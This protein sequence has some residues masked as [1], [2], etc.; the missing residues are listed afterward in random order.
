MKPE[1]DKRVSPFLI[2]P[3]KHNRQQMVDADA[4]TGDN[5]IDI[6]MARAGIT[7]R[8]AEIALQ[9][10]DETMNSSDQMLRGSLSQ[11]VAEAVR[12]RDR[13]WVLW[14]GK[15]FSML[16]VYTHKQR[17][18]QYVRMTIATMMFTLGYQMEAGVKTFAD[19]A[20]KHLKLIRR[21]SGKQTVTKC[22]GHF[23]KQLELAPMLSQRTK[24]ARAEM[25]AARRAQIPSEET[26][27]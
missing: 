22:A 9:V 3:P 10:L 19:I 6:C 11:A 27:S 1:E 12:E 8:Q 2:P 21:Q 23:L 18:V 14:L 25:E 13:Q 15:I 4:P 5:P 24:A 17:E 26:E 16:D 20:R 7:Q